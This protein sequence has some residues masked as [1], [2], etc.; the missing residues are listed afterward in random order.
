M[1]RYYL[2]YQNIALYT[3]DTIIMSA[4]R[5]GGWRRVGTREYGKVRRANKALKSRKG[6]SK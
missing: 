2:I 4:A 6:K 5:R 1:I 3:D